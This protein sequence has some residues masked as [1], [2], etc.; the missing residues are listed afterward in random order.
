MTALYEPLRLI[1][2]REKSNLSRPRFAKLIGASVSTLVRVETGEHEITDYLI[3]KIEALFPNAESYLR[4]ETMQV[5]SLNRTSVSPGPSHEGERLRKFLERRDVKQ[6]ALASMLGESPANINRIL[7]TENVRSDTKQ[8]IASALGVSVDEIFGP[9]NLL[10]FDLTDLVALPVFSV[11]D[12][13]LGGADFS[14][15]DWVKTFDYKKQPV[16]YLHRGEMTDAEVRDAF[17]LEVSMYDRMQPV[18]R[19]GSLALSI[20]VEEQEYDY[21]NATYVAV[22]IRGTIG[23]YRLVANNL[24]TSNSIQFASVEGIGS[25]IS[26]HREDIT[27]MARITKA[28]VELT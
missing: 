14:M 7:A 27:F 11:K 20:L 4:G 12:R 8:S 9:R 3:Q 10:K 24:R 2:L 6:N 13:N 22:S 25:A 19:P 26:L 23:V 16:Y 17:M 15:S 1:E 21:V 28:V 5:P 18:M